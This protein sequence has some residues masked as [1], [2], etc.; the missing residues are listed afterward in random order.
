[1]EAKITTEKIITAFISVVIGLALL[2]TVFTFVQDAV[3]NASGA[4]A[5]LVAL[6]PVFYVIGLVL[7]TIGVLVL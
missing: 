1:M 5:G 7:V 3:E 2:P 6:V 4:T